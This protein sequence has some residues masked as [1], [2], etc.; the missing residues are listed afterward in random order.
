VVGG[1]LRVIVTTN[2]DRLLENA[3]RERGIE[4]TIVASADALAGAEPITHSACY[5]L[6]LHG[7]Y[8]DA[9]ILNT[10]SE[11][12]AYPTQYDTLLDRI[13]DEFGL[14]V[15]GWSGEWD[16]ALRAALLRAPNRRYPVYWATRGT[17]AAITG[18]TDSDSQKANVGDHSGEFL[19]DLAL[20]SASMPHVRYPS[21]PL[22]TDN[23]LLA[24]APYI[25]GRSSCLR[26][27]P[28]RGGRT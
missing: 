4:P 26:E 7:D 10:D 14:I 27:T 20:R 13:F 1:Y 25:V 17:I 5:I 11:L 9:R 8:K 24:L 3:L 15:C 28:R 19:V 12:T 2:F 22:R 16:H 23:L 21:S 18:G 6:K